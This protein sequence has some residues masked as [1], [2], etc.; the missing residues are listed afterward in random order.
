M[1]LE[2]CVY[3][4]FCGVAWSIL[5]RISEDSD[6][7]AEAADVVDSARMVVLW[8]TQALEEQEG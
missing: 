6:E 3:V 1:W 8:A 7:A 2:P 4:S 5:G